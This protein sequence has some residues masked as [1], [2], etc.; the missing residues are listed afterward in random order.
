MVALRLSKA[1]FEG[2][3]KLL[4]K[5]KVNKPS[6]QAISVSSV[7]S[8]ALSGS[9]GFAI[10]SGSALFER[11]NQDASTSEITI[12]S[13]PEADSDLMNPLNESEASWWRGIPAN[14]PTFSRIGMNLSIEDRGV[15]IKLPSTNDAFDL[16]RETEI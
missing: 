2:M 12:A 8:D 5:A 14:A 15:P 11:Q 4:A 6:S 16:Q 10:R 9:S 3:A 7:A 13:A 1:A